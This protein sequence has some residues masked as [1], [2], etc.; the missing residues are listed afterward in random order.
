MARLAD[1]CWQ[2]TYKDV[3]IFFGVTPQRMVDKQRFFEDE[4]TILNAQMGPEAGGVLTWTRYNACMSKDD[5]RKTVNVL[6]TKFRL[7]LIPKSV[8]AKLLCG[9]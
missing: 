4:G 8:L 7:Q 6:F 3:C 5:N 9:C 1:A 2:R